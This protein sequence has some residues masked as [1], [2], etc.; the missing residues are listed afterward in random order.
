MTNEKKTYTVTRLDHWDDDQWAQI[1]EA[2]EDTVSELGED[3]EDF[4]CCEP[5]PESVEIT[6]AHFT[7]T[8]VASCQNCRFKSVYF[9][10]GHDLQHNCEE[11]E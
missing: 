3:F 2:I 6:R 1:V 9:E 8:A 11:Y 4:E 10:C 5:A 7:G